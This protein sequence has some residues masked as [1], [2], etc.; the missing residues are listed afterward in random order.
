VLV[1]AHVKHWFPLPSAKQLAWCC[2]DAGGNSRSPLVT[3]QDQRALE[4][5]TFLPSLAV[6][7]MPVTWHG[8]AGVV[9][10]A[11]AD[12]HP[13]HVPPPSMVCFAARWSGRERG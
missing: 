11:A 6:H 4:D 13:V 5:P 1:S 2:N 7:C 10:T 12:C 8:H 9:S 3:W